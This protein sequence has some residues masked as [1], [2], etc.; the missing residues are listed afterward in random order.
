MT[1]SERFDLLGILHKALGTSLS[2]ISPMPGAHASEMVTRISH[3]NALMHDGKGHGLREVIDMLHPSFINDHPRSGRHRRKTRVSTPWLSA[4][5][6]DARYTISRLC[7]PN[8]QSASRAVTVT[9]H[10][11]KQHIPVK[12]RNVRRGFRWILLDA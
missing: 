6:R 2:S 12:P 10:I 11:Y 7:I 4:L 3:T 9:A 5:R 1:L 8:K